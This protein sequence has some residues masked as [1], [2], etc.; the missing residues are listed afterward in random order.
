MLYTITQ[1]AIYFDTNADNVCK[2]I[3]IG[4]IN[5]IQDGKKRYIT[6]E[7]LERF[8][9]NNPKYCVDKPSIRIQ[10]LHYTRDTLE[11]ELKN[12]DTDDY[13]KEIDLK[14]AIFLTNRKLRDL[15]KI[16]DIM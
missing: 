4:K 2:W 5:V 9:T 15:E 13:R 1:V 3:S 6:N 12:L 16:K 10:K 7:E 8:K 14:K 11:Y